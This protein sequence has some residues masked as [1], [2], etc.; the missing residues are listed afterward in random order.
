VGD[1]ALAAALAAL[2]IAEVVVPF[3]SRQGSGSGWW[4]CVG[5]VGMCVVLAF[6]RLWPGPVA[7]AVLLAMPVTYAVHQTYVLF[8]GQ[9]VVLGVAAFT[10]ARY[11]RGREPAYAAAATVLT[12][13]FI[14]LRIPVMQEPGEIA[15][16][17]GVFVL[18]FAAGLTMRRMATRA[19]EAHDRAVAVEVAAAE[20]TFAAVLEERTRIARELHDIVAHAVSTMVVQAGAAEQVA[21]DDPA[22]A[23]E[24]LARIRASGAGA[25]AEMRRVVSMLRDP[26]DAQPLGPQPGLAAVDALVGD[27][28]RSGLDVSVETRDLPDDLPAGLDLTAYRVLQEALSNV[29]RHAHATQVRVRLVREHDRLLLEVTD[30][31]GGS[32]GAPFGHGLLGMRERVSLYGGTLHVHDEPG[33]GFAVEVCLPLEQP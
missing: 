28:R 26:D 30:D 3:S 2:G 9:F 24:A 23:R 4:T 25:L 33:T 29:R 31:G 7:V 20:A 17:W 15:F 19:R 11:G 14:D 8:F 27:A 6:R 18:V 10:A 16:H 32:G 22:Q 13:L 12:L 21:L 1:V 5:T